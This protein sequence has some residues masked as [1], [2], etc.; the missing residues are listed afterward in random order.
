MR[1]LCIFGIHK[2]DLLRFQSPTTEYRRC[3]C[4]STIQHKKISI[5]GNMVKLGHWRKVI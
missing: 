5:R 3:R 2:W 1:I 4:C